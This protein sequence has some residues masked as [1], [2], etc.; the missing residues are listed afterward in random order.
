MTAPQ[1]KRLWREQKKIYDGLYRLWHA[2][3]APPDPGRWDF[4][5]LAFPVTL[6]RFLAQNIVES[7]KSGDFDQS[8]P[9]RNL[10]VLVARR[11]QLQW[12]LIWERTGVEPTRGMTA[13]ELDEAQRRYRIVDRRYLVPV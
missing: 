13:A 12:L 11:Y 10:C 6:D 4:E 3:G 7:P 2:A 5:D 8:D 1:I 9:D